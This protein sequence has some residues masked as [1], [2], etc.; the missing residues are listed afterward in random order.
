[1]DLFG[2]LY[3]T[4]PQGRSYSYGTPCAVVELSC[5]HRAARHHTAVF[6]ATQPSTQKLPFEQEMFEREL[7]VD[8]RGFE[9]LT[10]C[11]PCRC[12]TSCATPPLGFASA[13]AATWKTLVHAR[14]RVKIGPPL[15]V[16]ETSQM[17]SG[18]PVVGH[19]ASSGGG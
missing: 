19:Q 14:M 2:V 13:L 6:E 5:T 8:L 10:P 4:S 16:E 17:R 15:L 12:A 1:M 18:V 3:T 11:M 9:P 7:L